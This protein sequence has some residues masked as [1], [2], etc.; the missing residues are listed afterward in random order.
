VM[1]SRVSN[2][3]G[4]PNFV[5]NFM[6]AGWFTYSVRTDGNIEIQSP[7]RF[8]RLNWSRWE[9]TMELPIEQQS[10]S[11]FHLSFASRVN[12]QWRHVENF[13]LRWHSCF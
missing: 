12:S 9:T 6:A 5:R 4:Y 3:M 13:L 7:K 2:P 10:K 1:G 11:I 8:N